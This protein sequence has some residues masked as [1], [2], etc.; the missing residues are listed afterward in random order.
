MSPGTSIP[1]Q[2]TSAL[3]NFDLFSLLLPFLFVFPRRWTRR[4][5]RF[6]VHVDFLGLSLPSSL[7]AHA[8]VP[9]PALFK[10]SFALPL[11]LHSPSVHPELLFFICFL[12]CTSSRFHPFPAL[13]GLVLVPV[14]PTIVLCQSMSCHFAAD[15]AIHH[16]CLSLLLLPHEAES[17][18]ANRFLSRIL[19]RHHPY[20]R[21][22]TKPFAHL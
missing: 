4:T 10:S 14:C 7:P 21:T 11:L 18:A 16:P 15:K 8:F 13:S 9:L 17:E 22:S 3:V 5:I 6:R 2:L 1:S 12:R 19:F 20:S